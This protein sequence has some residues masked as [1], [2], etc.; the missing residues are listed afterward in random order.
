[1]HP[2]STDVADASAT[3]LL[4]WTGVDRDEP[5]VR[6]LARYLE[7]AAGL[8]G[9]EV[10][11]PDDVER[12]AELFYRDGFVLVANA[13]DDEQLTRLRAGAEREMR[14]IVALDPQRA[15]NRGPRRYSFGSASLTGQLLHHPE[16]AMLVDLPT[17]TPIVEAIFGSA[18]YTVRGGGGDFCLPGAVRYQ[19]LHSDIG[20]RRTLRGK[21]FGSFFDPRG[22]LTY[23]D[24]P[25]P[26]LCCNF[27][28]AD[29]TALNGPTRQIPGTQHS[30][31]PMPRLAEEP[32]W[33]RLS[34]VNPAPAG[35]VLIR[36]VRA[37]HGGTPSLS[38][39]PRAIPNV[40]YFAPWYREPVE[41]S[42]PA[43]VFATLSERGQRICRFILLPRD[44][45]TEF[46]YRADLG[47]TP[48]VHRVDNA[49]S[50][51]DF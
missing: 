14:A 18:D 37:W 36:D 42:I 28:T 30:H 38:D 51:S 35:S 21:E 19:P 5:K 9:L 47:A 32:E 27:L 50:A 48:R 8:S 23:R 25:C 1:M 33:M 45:R 41:P 10:L 22:R 34:T 39:H 49:R 46:G 15:G 11:Q 29:Q 7:S 17:V 20:N 44:A 31:A 24:L 16:W 4:G 40:E 2:D 6:R 13:L 26:F 3:D 12:A 43:E